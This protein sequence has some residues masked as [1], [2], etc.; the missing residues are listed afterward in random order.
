MIIDNYN[1]TLGLEND[2]NE[3]EENTDI[4]NRFPLIFPNLI[5]NVHWSP[6]QD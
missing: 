5:I 1:K 4:K 6:K 2:D 3:N